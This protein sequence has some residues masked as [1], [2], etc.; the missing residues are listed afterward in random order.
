MCAGF[1]WKINQDSLTDCKM[2]SEICTSII[3]NRIIQQID[4]LKCAHNLIAHLS[5][6][7]KAQVDKIRFSNRV[8]HNKLIHKHITHKT[9]SIAL[10][11]WLCRFECSRAFSLLESKSNEHFGY[12]EH[13]WVS[14]VSVKYFL[15]NDLLLSC[16]T[17]VH[18][19]APGPKNIYI[20]NT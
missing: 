19:L 9:I 2:R 7:D 4:G 12:L 14:K 5:L 3:Q 15:I 18:L 11:H 1:H 10:F 13:A 16:P 6:Q 17:L 8:K 20:C